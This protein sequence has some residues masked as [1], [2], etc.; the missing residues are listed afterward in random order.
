MIGWGGGG[1]RM[2]GR[3]FRLRRKYELDS[4]LGLSANGK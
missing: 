4:E 1:G 3:I 2:V